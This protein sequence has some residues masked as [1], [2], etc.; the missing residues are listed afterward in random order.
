M[1]SQTN[2]IGIRVKN[3]VN[4]KS[5]EQWGLGGDKPAAGERIGEQCESSIP[6][7]E[8]LWQW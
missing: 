2:I 6:D 5:E 7:V 8:S 3:G 4:A 1:I